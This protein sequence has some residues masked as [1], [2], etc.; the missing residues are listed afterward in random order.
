MKDI[1]VYKVKYKIK[2]ICMYI[3]NIYAYTIHNTNDK[4][5]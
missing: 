5:K 4:L 2:Y 1:E 3:Y